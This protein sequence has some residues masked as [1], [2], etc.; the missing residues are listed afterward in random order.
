MINQIGPQQSTPEGDAKIPFRK[1][2]RHSSFC[3]KITYSYIWMLIAS[4]KE[5]GGV[6]T[7][8]MIE[9]MKMSDDE[10]EEQVA[11]FL[12]HLKKRE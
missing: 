4:M 12:Y 3:S 2:L 11:R 7:E 5:N 9:D 10:T 6:M 8:D 1:S